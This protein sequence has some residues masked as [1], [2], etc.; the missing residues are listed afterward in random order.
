MIVTTQAPLTESN[1]KVYWFF[2]LHLDLLIAKMLKKRLTFLAI[3]SVSLVPS[4][5]IQMQNKHLFWLTD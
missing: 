4:K 3:V 5:H 1:H 2:L